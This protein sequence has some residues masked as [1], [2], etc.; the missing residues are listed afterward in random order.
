M[1]IKLAV[2]LLKLTIGAMKA[3]QKPVTKDRDENGEV[4]IANP[5]TMIWGHK[6]GMNEKM[7]KQRM[8]NIVR[9][10]MS[11]LYLCKG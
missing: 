7:L 2:I 4:S 5:L 8:M 9:V 3:T 10:V 6:H 1:Q 11:R